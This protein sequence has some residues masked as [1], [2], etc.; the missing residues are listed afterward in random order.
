MRYAE[1]MR[2]PS[3]APTQGSLRAT[4]GTALPLEHTQVRAVVDGPIAE[5]V[6]T[7]RFR[8]TGRDPIEAVYAFPLPG[9]A[10][11]FRMTLRI[12]DRVCA[13]S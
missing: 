12:A 4:D 1:G 9:D 13:R 2:D 10:S 3:D 5:V 11:V 6:A 7:Q 8:N